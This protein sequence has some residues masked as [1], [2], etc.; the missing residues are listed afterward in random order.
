MV[1]PAVRRRVAAALPLLGLLHTSA[2]QTVILLSGSGTAG[3]ADGAQGVA[4]HNV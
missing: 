2:A 3:A 4:R 1:I